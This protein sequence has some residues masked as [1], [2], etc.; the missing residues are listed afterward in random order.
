MP[1]APRLMTYRTAKEYL[2]IG[3]TKLR[4]LV[5]AGEIPS[6]VEIGGR[7]HFDREELDKWA[8]R[9]IKRRRR[10]Q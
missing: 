10:G 1:N 9:E 7:P 6:P 4:A 3:E 5:A 2:D 8:V